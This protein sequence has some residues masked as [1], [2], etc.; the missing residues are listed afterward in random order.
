MIRA[1]SQPGNG[2]RRLFG[3]F[4]GTYLLVLA[5]AGADVVNTAT[6]GGLGHTAMVMT[7]ALMIIA[8]VLF[9]GP[10]SG[11]HLNPVVTLAFALR[12]DFPWPRVPGYVLVQAAGAM[13]ASATLLAVFG[14]YGKDG[15]TVPGPEFSDYQA[16]TVEVLLTAGL[17]S[18]VLAV[19]SGAQ[20]VG[21]L[22]AF[23]IAAYIVM[24]GLWAGPVSG[25]SM[26]P[27]RSFAPDLITGD[28]SRF[29]IYA[30]GPVAGSLLAVAIARV[31]RGRGG[32]AAAERAAQGTLRG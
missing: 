28:F 14:H 9:I 23:G 16:F 13:L 21:A 4:L 19:A 5:A 27:I 11:A 8:V 22:S 2:S 32:E 29:W 20:N 6:H 3:E 12:R 1:F 10:I 15:M 18:T 24:A 17:V 30:T 31:L 26:N 7:P 25:A